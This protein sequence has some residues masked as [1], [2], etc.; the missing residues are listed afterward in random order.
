MGRRM[1]G[2]PRQVVA[3][4][5]VLLTVALNAAML[6]TVL[7]T[8]VLARLSASQK[9]ALEGAG[10]TSFWAALQRSPSSPRLLAH[11]LQTAPKP[12]KSARFCSLVER[13]W[14]EVSSDMSSVGSS[15]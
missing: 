7:E 12:P 5:L 14:R 1:M 2:S 4:A 3:I 10:A 11:S 15:S 9:T 13:S 6:W 8:D